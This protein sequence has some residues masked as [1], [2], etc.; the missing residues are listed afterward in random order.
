MWLR[1]AFYRWL[2]PAAFVLPL[3]LLIGWIVF[4]ASPWALLWVIVSAPVI[5]IGQIILT[6]LVRARGTVRAERAASW[7]DVGLIGAW[8]VLVIALGVFDESWWWPTLAVTVAVGIAALVVSFRQLW[9]EARPSPVVLRTASGTAY[10]P[11]AAPRDTPR[12]A[13]SP[14]VFVV[15]E[16]PT[17]P[18]S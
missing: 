7:T 9:R 12:D 18:A 17:P 3:W 14:D 16:K 1:E 8:H 2:I 10:I 15:T 13:S 11:P 5:L 6:L 4:G